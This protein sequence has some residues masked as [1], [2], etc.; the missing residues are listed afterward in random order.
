MGGEKFRLVPRREEGEYREYSTDEERGQPRWIGG[1]MTRLFAPAAL[2][3]FTSIWQ[4]EL[5]PS[6]SAVLP[7]SHCS[8]LSVCTMPSPHTAPRV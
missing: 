3:Q 7:S 2:A 4:S 5:Q 8:P 6:P 1:Q